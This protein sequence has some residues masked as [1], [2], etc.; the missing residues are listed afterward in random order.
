MVPALSHILSRLD[1][2][3]LVTFRQPDSLAGH[4]VSQEDVGQ[5]ALVLAGQQAVQSLIVDLGEGLVGR[6]EE[7]EGSEVGQGPLGDVGG[8]E[9][10]HQG[11]ELLVSDQGRHQGARAAGA[12]G[13]GL[14]CVVSPPSR[15]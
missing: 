9:G 1:W 11:G 10:G 3:G 6:S 8:L 5:S 2:T 14:D 15:N 13:D 4:D 7:G 12:D